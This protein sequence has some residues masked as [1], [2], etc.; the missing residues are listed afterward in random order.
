VTK[1]AIR[2][3]ADFMFWRRTRRWGI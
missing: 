1:L 2:A 3:R